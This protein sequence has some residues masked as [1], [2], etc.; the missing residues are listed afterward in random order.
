[1]VHSSS[2]L[3]R[4]PLT[5][6]TRVRTPDALLKERATDYFGC[7]FFCYIIFL[8]VEQ[9]SVVEHKQ[10]ALQSVLLR[11]VKLQVEGESYQWLDYLIHS[12]ISFNTSIAIVSSIL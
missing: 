2:G 12:T 1:M 3:G 8:L 7:S 9:N 6:E 11:H 4:W 5:P 10:N